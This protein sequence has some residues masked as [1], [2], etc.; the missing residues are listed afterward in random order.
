MSRPPKLIAVIHH[1]D[2]LT[3]YTNAELAALAGYAGVVLIQMD[4]RDDELD[5]PAATLKLGFPELIVG[6]NRLSASPASAIAT[7]AVLDLDFTWSD[8]PGAS[9][10]GIGP[11]ASGINDM[12]SKARAGGRRH[13]YFGSVAFKTQALERNPAGAAVVAA[14]MGWI[15]TTSGPATGKAPAP[16]KLEAMKAAIGEFELAVASGVTPENASLI[17]PHVDWILVATGI[18]RDFHEFDPARVLDLAQAVA[19]VSTTEAA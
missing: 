10:D 14:N 12:L 1:R 13:R 19:A 8:N 2:N 6:T 4:G 16:E 3:T 17:A 15:P 18:S 11:L 7:D 5:H 9:S